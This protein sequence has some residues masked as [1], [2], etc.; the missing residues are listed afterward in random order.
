MTSD[1]IETPCAQHTDLQTLLDKY[2]DK[3]LDCQTI[4]PGIVA[5]YA[6]SC[7][8]IDIASSGV[9]DHSAEDRN[10]AKNMMQND[11]TFLL[12]STTK[13][14][15]VTGLFQLIEADKISLEDPIEKYLPN[16][17]GKKVALEVDDNGSVTKKENMRITPQIKHLTTHTLGLAYPFFN[18]KYQKLMDMAN[19]GGDLLKAN[20]AE[21][22]D[23]PLSFQPGTKWEYGLNI[24]YLGLIIEKITGQTLNEYLKE[25][26]FD[27]C[28]MTS[29]SFVR[30]KSHLNSWVKLH[31]RDT[32]STKKFY[33]VLQNAD[34]TPLNP[35]THCGGHGCFGKVEDYLKFLQV[36]INKGVQPQTGAQ[37]LQEDTIMSSVFKDQLPSMGKDIKFENLPNPQPLVSNPVAVYPETSKGWSHFLMVN[38]D[39]IDLG[40]EIYR[41]KNSGMWCGLANL[42]YVI[43]LEKKVVLYWAEQLFPFADLSSLIGFTEFEKFVYK[44]IQI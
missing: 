42:Y 24:D 38:N 36:F 9:L 12:W 1:P 2:T 32:T 8:I 22:L 19:V 10:A 29:F 5:G 20:A 21:F 15:T 17:A 44:Q 7:K 25:N 27:K 35:K 4:I 43:D 30:N 6:N 14:L 26:I 39:P 40:D 18:E 28:G 37:I 23:L 13:L 3:N 34:Y 11:S 16:F 41:S 31:T 33:S